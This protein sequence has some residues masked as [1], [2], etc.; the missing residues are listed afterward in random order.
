[1]RG[2]P[3]RSVPG[4]QLLD[5]EAVLT[6]TVQGKVAVIS[7]GSTGVGKATAK[8]LAANGAHVVLLARRADRLEAAVG[9]MDGSVLAIPTDVSDG[10]SVRAAF[11]QVGERFGR[12]D[13]LVNSAGVARVRSIEETR[14]ED[15]VA[16]IGTNLLGPIH[17]IRSAV[18]LMRAAGGGDIVNISSEITLDHMPLM[19][20]YAASKHGLNGFTAAMRRE[21]RSEGIR[22]SLVI[23]G[24]VADSAFHENFTGDDRQ[25]AQPVW[26]AD[27][28]LTRVGAMKPMPSATVA[29]LLH[30]LLDAPPEV[31]QDVVHIRPAG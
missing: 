27:G 18:P 12:L 3:T 9:D 15:I 11:A 29:G 22:V 31:A 26:E 2:R 1:M 7:G 13:I 24:S 19:A 17:T 10:G 14:D 30:Q 16:C 25:R 20:M 6:G 23:L 21:L 4:P 5:R 28:Y 8:L